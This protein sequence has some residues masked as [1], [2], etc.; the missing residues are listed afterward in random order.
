MFRLGL[1]S[2]ILKHRTDTPIYAWTCFR[3]VSYLL[4]YSSLGS[5]VR[6]LNMIRSLPVLRNLFDLFRTIEV[7]QMDYSLQIKRSQRKLIREKRY[8]MVGISVF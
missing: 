2:R 1:P 6:P 5:P 7:A 8:M 3:L 4:K